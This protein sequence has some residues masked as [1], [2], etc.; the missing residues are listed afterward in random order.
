MAKMTTKEALRVL[1]SDALADNLL[2]EADFAS[3]GGYKPSDDLADLL[4]RAARALAEHD[5]QKL[6]RKAAAELQKQYGWDERT[7]ASVMLTITTAVRL[8]PR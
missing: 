1:G 4:L 6:M 8:A 2:M 3:S 7:A 5:Q